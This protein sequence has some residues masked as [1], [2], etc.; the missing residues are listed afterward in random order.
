MKGGK[1]TIFRN[2]SVNL[3][4]KVEDKLEPHKTTAVEFLEEFD[5]VEYPRLEMPK[6]L[7]GEIFVEEKVEVGSS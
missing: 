1:E 6:E 2:L 5:R 3:R 7:G 4:P